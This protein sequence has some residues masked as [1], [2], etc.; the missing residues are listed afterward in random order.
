MVEHQEDDRSVDGFIVVKNRQSV[1]PRITKK[2]HK[3][4]KQVNDIVQR[5][6]PFCEQLKKLPL[7]IQNTITESTYLIYNFTNMDK[8]TNMASAEMCYSENHG[9]KIWHIFTECMELIEEGLIIDFQI[10]KASFE[11]AYERIIYPPAKPVE[12]AP[13]SPSA[14]RAGTQSGRP[15]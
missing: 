2:V 14:V 6:M 7:R 15:E 1:L 3:L 5:K 4:R 8:Y 9:Q 10:E 13:K 12:R 11:Q